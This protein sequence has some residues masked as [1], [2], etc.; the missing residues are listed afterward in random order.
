MLRINVA[1]YLRSFNIISALLSTNTP[2]RIIT[3][4]LFDN[5]RSVLSAVSQ[6]IAKNKHLLFDTIFVLYNVLY[7]FISSTV[8]QQLLSSDTEVTQQ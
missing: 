6:N 4:A 3:V 2:E 7:V 1:T 8:T 5:I